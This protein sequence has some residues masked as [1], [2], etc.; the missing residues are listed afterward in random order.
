[1]TAVGKSF[2]NGSR[3]TLV[4]KWSAKEVSNFYEVKFTP[5]HENLMLLLRF[6]SGAAAVAAAAWEGN[7]ALLISYEITDR[8]YNISCTYL[9]SDEYRRLFFFLEITLTW[10]VLRFSS[11]IITVIPFSTA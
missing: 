5:T 8:N 9:P 11:C 4:R 3:D 10:I 6:T 7:D 2:V 1:M